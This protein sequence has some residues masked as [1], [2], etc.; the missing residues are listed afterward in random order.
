VSGIK[1]TPCPSCRKPVPWSDESPYRPFCSKRCQLVDFGDWA[2]ERH[3]IP[4]EEADVFS[5]DL[6]GGG[7][8]TPEG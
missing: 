1:E 4:Q 7:E 3:R 5:D 6:K 2:N 8:D